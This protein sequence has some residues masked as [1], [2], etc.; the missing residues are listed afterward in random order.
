M[1]LLRTLHFVLLAA[2]MLLAPAP[3]L[4]IAAAQQGKTQTRV[5]MPPDAQAKAVDE[6]VAA[7]VRY[8]MSRQNADGSISADTTHATALTALAAMAMIGVGHQVTDPTLEGEG[9]ATAGR[10]LGILGIVFWA[11][12]LF[13]RLGSS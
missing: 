2:A 4:P 12:Y 7:G 5:E 8:L 1:Y 10:V 9:L 13:V 3:A 11:I 6:A